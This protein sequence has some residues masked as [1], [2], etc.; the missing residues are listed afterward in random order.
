MWSNQ[1]G[2]QPGR[3]LAAAW[4]RVM[5]EAAR[6]DNYS[7]PWNK[8]LGISAASQGHILANRNVDD[9]RLASQS[10]TIDYFLLLAFPL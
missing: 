2:S 6:G 5:V 3:S 10:G 1:L 8:M 4:N 9:G 7:I